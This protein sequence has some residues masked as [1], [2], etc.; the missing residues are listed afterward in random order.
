MW[1]KV[2]RAEPYT[3]DGKNTGVLFLV[4]NFDYPDPKMRRMGT[5]VDKER[6]LDLFN[7]M[8]FIIFYYENLTKQEFFDLMKQLSNSEHLRSADCLFFTVMTFAY[9]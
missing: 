1:I 4:N 5:E 9:R 8:G 6:M 3:M 7:Q 2:R